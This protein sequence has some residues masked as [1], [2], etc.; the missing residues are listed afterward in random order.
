MQEPDPPCARDA[1]G[2]RNILVDIT[3]CEEE[4]GGLDVALRRHERPRDSVVAD[5]ARADP[6]VAEILI[7]DPARDLLEVEHLTL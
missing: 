2:H 7:L 4:R 3:R 6:P 1:A 5:A